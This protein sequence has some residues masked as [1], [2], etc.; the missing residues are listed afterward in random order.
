MH[1]GPY[2]LPG[3]AGLLYYRASGEIVAYRIHEKDI[4][5]FSGGF[6]LKIKTGDTDPFGNVLGHPDTTHYETR[7]WVYEFTEEN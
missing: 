7:V 1:S 4:L 2:T 6:Q 3:Y 5:P